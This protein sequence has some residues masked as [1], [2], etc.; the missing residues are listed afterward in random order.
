MAKQ[1]AETGTTTP[2]ET[3]NVYAALFRARKVFG[4]VLKHA[5]NPHFKSKFASLGAI[6]DA[7]E[8]ALLAEGLLLVQT[9]G[10]TELGAVLR[11]ELILVAEP[12]QRISSVYPLAPAKGND[13]QALGGALTYARR[14]Q[15][16]TILGLVPE[17]DDGETA[18]GR[19]NR[20]ERQADEK[21]AS[22]QRPTYNEAVTRMQSARTMKELG[23]VWHSLPADL[24]KQ[25]VQDKDAAK[26]R[27][28][29]YKAPTPGPTEE[30]LQ[31]EEQPVKKPA[32]GKK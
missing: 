6:L 24:Q 12:G 4:P 28:A 15:A 2:A 19:G 32:R 20:R 9:T 17:D 13:P 11:T 10:Y 1:T 18:S 3:P 22:A 23:E 27:I 14:Y 30:A 26:E 31:T 5:T 7:V 29:S 8:D 25:L 16:L 21:P